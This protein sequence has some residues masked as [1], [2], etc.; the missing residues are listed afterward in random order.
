MNPTT[1][2][3]ALLRAEGHA[4]AARMHAENVRR[5]LDALA[6]A[7]RGLPG[8][9]AYRLAP[10]LDAAAESVADTE[11][12]ATTAADAA[13]SASVEYERERA[14]AVAV[15]RGMIEAAEDVPTY[16]SPALYASASTLSVVPGAITNRIKRGTLKPDAW[17]VNPDGSRVPLFRDEDAVHPTTAQ[18]LTAAHDTAREIVAAEEATR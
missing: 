18:E 7:L 17:K 9:F 15:A 13:R 12:A 6:D 16:Y 8:C 5:D 14:D 3:A 1:T 11:R 2:R 4:D 10:M